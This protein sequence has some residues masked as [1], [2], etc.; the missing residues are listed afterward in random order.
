MLTFNKSFT[1]TLTTLACL[2]LSPSVTTCTLAS[3]LRVTTGADVVRHSH[4]RLLSLASYCLKSIN[5]D[6]PLSLHT[7][8]DHTQPPHNHH[9]H[10]IHTIPYT[11]MLSLLHT[12]PRAHGLNRS[13]SSPPL[14]SAD[15]LSLSVIHHDV[16]TLSLT[17]RTS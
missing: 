1:N 17:Q 11:P 3:T 12:L 7:T 5:F 14:S 6:V 15:A 16:Y 13:N 4:Q 10:T 2:S 8:Q 9:L